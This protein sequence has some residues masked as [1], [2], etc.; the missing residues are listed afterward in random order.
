M[1]ILPQWEVQDNDQRV[2]WNDPNITKGCSLFK[3]EDVANTMQLKMS[4]LQWAFLKVAITDSN[5]LPIISQLDQL[6]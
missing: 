3:E 2:K 5:K 4:P 6:K 1:D